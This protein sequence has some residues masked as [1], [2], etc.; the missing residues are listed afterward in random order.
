MW[1]QFWNT[2]VDQL[3]SVRIAYSLFQDIAVN[4]FI[5]NKKQ[6]NKQNT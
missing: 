2:F 6:V 4:H 1:F 5:W 3:N